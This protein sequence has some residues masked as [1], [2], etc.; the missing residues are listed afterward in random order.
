MNE[1]S[2]K[3][4]CYNTSHLAGHTV[5]NVAAGHSKACVAVTADRR[6]ICTGTPLSNDIIDLLGQ[7]SV[8]QME[9]FG[10]KTWFDARIK[11]AFLSE[12]GASIVLQATHCQR[13]PVY[14]FGML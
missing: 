2:F 4:T 8:L 3:H 12:L 9:P 14:R 11:T 1:P 6:W 5:K 13:V 7:F 10:S